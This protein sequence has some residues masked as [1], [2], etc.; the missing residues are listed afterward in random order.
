MNDSIEQHIRSQGILFGKYRLL[1]KLAQGGMAE[2]FLAQ[3][4]GL[5]GFSK[6]VA[7][8]C[9]LPHF[10]QKEDFITMFLDEARIAAHLNHPNVVQILDI[11]EVNGV[12][13]MAM[14]YIPGQNLKE[15]HKKLYTHPQ[16]KQRPPYEMVASVFAQACAGLDHVHNS[17]D[18]HNQP[19]HLVHR[20]ISPNNLLL[21]YDGILKIVDFG[22][23]K[24]RSQ[25]YETEVGVLKGRLSYMSPEQLSAQ[26]IDGRSDLFALGIVLYE[27]TTHKRLFRRRSEAE[28]IQ[29]LLTNPIPPP[30]RIIDSYPKQLEDIVLRALRRK[31]ED[32]FQSAAEM[33]HALEEYIA[34]TGRMY[35]GRQSAGMLEELFPEEIQREKDGQYDHYVNQQDLFNLSRGSYRVIRSHDHSMASIQ[36]TT[37]E[38][39]GSHTGAWQS[40]PSQVLYNPNTAQPSPY[41]LPSGTQS[42]IRRNSRAE[43]D[44]PYAEQVEQYNHAVPEPAP[45]PSQEDATIVSSPSHERLKAAPPPSS[46]GIRYED[47]T[48]VSNSQ[49]TDPAEFGAPATSRRGSQ[50][51]SYG[52][53]PV[54]NAPSSSQAP[55]EHENFESM[56]VKENLP[57]EIP[58]P[59]RTSPPTPTVQEEEAPATK[60]S[61]L[62][63]FLVFLVLGVGLGGFAVWKFFLAPPTPQ[64][65]M[66][67]QQEATPP[68]AGESTSPIQI[69]HPDAGAGSIAPPVPDSS[70]ITLSKTDTPPQP[71]TPR[72]E[73]PDPVVQ[74]AKRRIKPAPRRRKTR[75]R[76]RQ[77][78]S[79]GG[80]KALPWTNVRIDRKVKIAV[81][82]REDGARKYTSAHPKLCRKIEREA[83]RLLGRKH[84]I[85]GVTKAWQKFVKEKFAKGRRYKYSFYPRAV[86]YVIYRDTLKGVSKSEI[87]QKLVKYQKTYAF[88]RY[89]NK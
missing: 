67:A 23:A 47:P 30:T 60:R 21:S 44:L 56:E 11:G 34:S 62:P 14:E 68:D 37:P 22:V 40:Q 17:K 86:V 75:P 39:T 42:G 25:E 4:E 70:P 26:P 48:S 72:P 46:T 2:L 65:P 83:A 81:Y 35:G 51:S 10:A 76:P 32:R 53:R 3:Q 28:T 74:P 33:R 77:R 6:K 5:A 31:P 69:Q 52:A 73:T 55:L 15:V 89:K 63:I 58:P 1:A 29:A 61:G 9:I 38:N 84:K 79:R 36:I 59:A 45:P 13:Y 19:L 78:A 88:G 18:Q 82:E 7:I 43:E 66:L 80:S 8:K 49:S 85:A 16:Y 54:E 71:P 12:Y 20:D 64:G 27:I 57:P 50:T 41:Q 24:A 87:A